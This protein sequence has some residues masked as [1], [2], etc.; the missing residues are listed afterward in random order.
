[1]E[2]CFICKKHVGNIQTSGMKIF[3]DD[4]VYVGHID[5]NGNNV[6]E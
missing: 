5:R 2:E 3:E 4:F 1:M 6:N